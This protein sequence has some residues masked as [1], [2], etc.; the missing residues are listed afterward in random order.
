MK[1]RCGRFLE[2]L[3]VFLL[4]ILQNISNENWIFNQNSAVFL[5]V[6]KKRKRG[7]NTTANKTNKPPT[8][9]SQN[10]SLSSP[11]TP[12][13]ALS[14]S[15]TSKLANSVGKAASMLSRFHAASSPATEKCNMDDVTVYTHE[16][17]EWLTE[18]KIRFQMN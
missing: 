3:N 15:L 13:S 8:T 12:S 6:T 5:K 14:S 2:S 17:L 4:S 9:P 18:Q 11:K 7:K 16:K 1:E 10:S